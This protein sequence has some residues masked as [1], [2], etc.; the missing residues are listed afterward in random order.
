MLAMEI[1]KKINE[2]KQL[3]ALELKGLALGEERGKQP[4]VPITTLYHSFEKQI[5]DLGW[6]YAKKDV[7]AMKKCLADIRNVAGIFFLNLEG[8]TFET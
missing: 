3:K 4:N 6:A 7:T 5:D 2:N 8:E 1:W